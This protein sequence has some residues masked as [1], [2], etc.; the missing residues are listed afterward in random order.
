V[1]TFL[2]TIHVIA[3]VLVIGPM[4]AAPFYGGRAVARRNPAIARAAGNSLLAFGAASLLASAFGVLAVGNSSQYHF[5]TP[6]IIISVTVYVLVLVLAIGYTAPACRKAARLMESLATS[7]AAAN[8]PRLAEIPPTPPKP[9]PLA[10]SLGPDEDDPSVAAIQADLRVKQQIDE[11]VG[12]IT[13]SGLLILLGMVLIV[14]LMVIRP[15]G[16]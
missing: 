16:D 6:W 12:R 10:G 5:G 14:V 3:V 8:R 11:I 9:Q 4:V 1:G 15:F 13:G 7:A 2:V